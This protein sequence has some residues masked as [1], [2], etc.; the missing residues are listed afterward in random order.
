MTK[1]RRLLVSL[2]T[3]LLISTLPVACVN[4]PQLKDDAGNPLPTPAD[5]AR[6]ESRVLGRWEALIN[7]DFELAYEYFSP[8]YRKLFPLQHYL[9]RTGSSVRWLSANIKDSQYAETRAEVVVVVDFKLDLPM[10]E[11]D[12]FGQISKDLKETWLWVDDQWW[13]V[14][15]VDGSLR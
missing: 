9:S 13:Y 1:I 2:T 8:S 11:G 6:L 5:Y 3:L 7:K 15:D 12:G 10:G 14:S 4:S